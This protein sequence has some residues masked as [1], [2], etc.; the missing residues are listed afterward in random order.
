MS[1][2]PI[3][4]TIRRGARWKF[5]RNTSQRDLAVITVIARRR[6]AYHMFTSAFWCPAITYATHVTHTKRHNRR[7]VVQRFKSTR[8][9]S[10][11]RWCTRKIKIFKTFK[12]HI[13]YISN[14]TFTKL[15]YIH[16]CIFNELVNLRFYGGSQRN[17]PPLKNIISE[18]LT[19]LNISGVC[20]FASKVLSAAAPAWKEIRR[21][22]F[23][24]FA[25]SYLFHNAYLIRQ[26]INTC[27]FKL[28]PLSRCMQKSSAARHPHTPLTQIP[29]IP[30]SV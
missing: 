21:L 13:F 11:Q 26:F 14:P 27:H 3:M 29:A 2:R 16:A 23:R 1:S 17:W 7:L 10:F 8:R 19:C 18:C 12:N 22:P 5:S 9:A 28:G 15:C 20:I 24:I 6:W 30:R 4:K 25:T